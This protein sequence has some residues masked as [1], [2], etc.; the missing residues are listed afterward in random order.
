MTDT[1]TSTSPPRV[2]VLMA[3]RNGAPWIGE[4]LA[5]IQA[6]RDVA[7]TLLVSDDASTDA[8]VAILRDAAARDPRLQ[9]IPHAVGSG[10]AG[11][12]FR[13][14]Y[15]VADASACDYV[16]LADQDDL[17]APDKLASAIRAMRA[18]GADGYS[19]AVVA[20]GTAPDDTVLTQSSRIRHADFLFEGAGQGCT[21]VL[22]APLF[23]RAQA[24]CIAQPLLTE[25]LHYH[26]WLL[27]LLARAWS[28]RWLFD[29]TPS[30]RYR[31]H[32][33]NEIGARGGLRSIQRRIALIT[34]GWYR[35]QVRAACALYVA[36]GG[37]DP[38]AL[39][40]CDSLLGEVAARGAAARL[41]LAGRVLR[42]GRRKAADRLVLGACALADRL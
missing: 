35:Q 32:A 26:D 3:T 10:S 24:F 34:N 27:Y 42:D 39:R 31:Q 1:S 2:L 13:R 30:M 25:A 12:N 11:A 15:R 28:E 4:Q 21:F 8:T 40:L 18:A 5:S 23:R 36:A 38:Q 17:W 14:L 9:V 16:A 37:A 20:F 6:Q 19:A 22:A 33:S 41:T 7:L 29:P